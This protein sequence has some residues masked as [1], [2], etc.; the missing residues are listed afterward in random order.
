MLKNFLGI[1]FRNFIRHPSYAIINITGLTVG[2]TCCILILGIVAYEFSFDRYHEHA[3]NIYRIISESTVNGVSTESASCPTR[4][5]PTLLND[6]PEVI[7]AARITP[8]VR[9]SFIYDD[10]QFFESNV[11]YAD[12]SIFN[13]FSFELIEGD[14]ETALEAP[15]TMVITENTARKYFGDESPVG[16]IMNWDNKFDYAITGVVKDPLP[17]SHFTFTVLA[18]FTTFFSYDPRL[19]EYWW[20]W[21]VPTYIRLEDKTDYKSF[22]RKFIQF[23]EQYLGEV[24]ES[25]GIVLKNRLEPLKEI[26]LYSTVGGG[27]GDYGNIKMMFVFISIAIVI[28]VIA[29]INFMNLTTARFTS[30][31]KEVGVRKVLGAERK[32]LIIQFLSESALYGLLSLILAVILVQLVLPLFNNLTGREISARIIELPWLL[33]SFGIILLLVTAIAGLYPSFFLSA[34][35]P[36]SVLKG[37][38]MQGAKNHLFRSILV[39][40]QFTISILLVIITL[41]IRDQQKYLAKKELGFEKNNRLV[42]A[43]QNDDVRASLESFKNELQKFN[44]VVSTGSSSMV[45][46]EMYLFNTSAY[47]EGF[48]PDQ[49]ISIQNFR[50]DYGYFNALEIEIIQ[51][52]GF[53]RDF[54]ADHVNGIIINETAVKMLQWKDPIGK[55]LNVISSLENNQSHT[56]QWEVIG[57]CKDFHNRSL[58]TTISPLFL[59]YIGTEGPIENRPRRLIVKL[60]EID[61]PEIMVSIKKK[62]EEFYPEIPYYAFFLDES[63]DSQHRAEQRLSKIFMVFALLAIFIAC[64]GLLGLAAFTAEQR[65]REIGIRKVFGSTANAVVILLCKKYL[66]LIG[67]STLI[68]WPVAYLGMVKWLHNYPYATDLTIS[69]FLLSATITLLLALLTVSYQS[70]KAAL[71]NPAESLRYE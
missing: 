53:S 8:T 33:I 45:P 44:G 46:G 12:Q 49:T 17:N 3:D 2:I 32:G 6:F 13:V 21:N 63:Y 10:K 24:L 25:R 56:S 11:Y 9:R 23:N 27:L 71:I 68:A 5:A 41:V 59:N 60:G 29:C 57:V 42:I 47:P 35:K 66:G 61:L 50:V 18:S 1:T 7:D 70:A 22:E 54:L 28:L 43:L 16:K 48:T 64:L 62:W 65:T 67:L 38:I 55:K 4:F 15:F 58:Y 30:R 52:R 69:P 19:A 14:P 37:R 26:H 20:G 34:F 39:V 31:A 36:I 51:G 40:F